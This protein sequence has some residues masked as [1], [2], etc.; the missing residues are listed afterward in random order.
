MN[1]E[2]LMNTQ[3]NTSSINEDYIWECYNSLLLSHDIERVR[4]LLVRY[5]LFKLSLDIPGDMK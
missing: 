1:G 5:E 4:K 2:S 3:E